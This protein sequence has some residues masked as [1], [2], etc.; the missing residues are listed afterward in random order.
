VTAD[1]RSRP[2]RWREAVA[3]LLELQA[4]YTAWYDALPETLHNS[5]TAEALQD[6]VEIDLDSLAAINPPRGYGRD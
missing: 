1:R 4:H 6:I 3:V 2:Q 5:P